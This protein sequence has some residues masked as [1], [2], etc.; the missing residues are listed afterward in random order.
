MGPLVALPLVLLLGG[1]ALAL[2]TPGAQ[3]PPAEVF[4]ARVQAF[5]SGASSVSYVLRV[6]TGAVNVD[7]AARRER[8]VLVLPDRSSSVTDVDRFGRLDVVERIRV[9]DRSWVRYRNGRPDH[10]FFQPESA[11]EASLGPPDPRS[12]VAQDR[13]RILALDSTS[14]TLALGAGGP[15]PDTVVQADPTT[16]R[17][18]SVQFGRTTIDYRDWNALAS[19][20]AP[21][22]AEID[23]TPGV[24]EEGIL[25]EVGVRPLVPRDLPRRWVLVS[26]GVE[27]DLQPDGSYRCAVAVLRYAEPADPGGSHLALR[28]GPRVDPE[29]PVLP[30][31]RPGG[32]TDLTIL[33][34]PGWIVDGAEVTIGLDLPSVRIVATSDRSGRA[35]ATWLATLDPIELVPG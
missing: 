8:G 21:P 27:G 29:C 18:H 15:V 28:E 20:A 22:T 11:A 5:V 16:G 19:V 12:W 10:A 30:G 26:G 23:T 4:L 2:S 14:V 6:T 32:A 34:S 17:L 25:R 35:V 13:V 31:G 1:V 24:D 3:R 7:I 9:G 33:G